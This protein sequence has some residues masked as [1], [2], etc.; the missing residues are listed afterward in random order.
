[1][2]GR[3][4]RLKNECQYRTGIVR[5]V[6]AFALAYLLFFSSLLSF[7]APIPL[8]GERHHFDQAICT[9]DDDGASRPQIPDQHNDVS[10]C[11]TA[12]PFLALLTPTV[13]TDSEP[14]A[15]SHTDQLVPPS[16]HCDGVAI[17]AP[18]SARA[19]PLAA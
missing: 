3:Q 11:L 6:T 8:Q 12:L 17:S 13:R 19:P 18:V 10:C 4:N 15:G 1:M 9:N 16:L 14:I 2:I 5:A 7:A